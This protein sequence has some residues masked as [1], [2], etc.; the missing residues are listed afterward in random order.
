M[1]YHKHRLDPAFSIKPLRIDGLVADLVSLKADQ[2]LLFFLGAGCSRS[3]GIPTAAEL[4]N[5]R[6][7]P[8]LRERYDPKW[9]AELFP[10]FNRSYGAEHYGAVFETLYPHPDQR[11]REI[12]DLTDGVMPGIGYALL[13]QIMSD[14][15]RRNFNIVLTT[16]FDDLLQDSLFLYA[17]RKPLAVIHESL[18]S[19]VDSKRSRPTVVKIHGDARIAPKNTDLETSR[20]DSAVVT[21]VAELLRSTGIVFLGYGGGD[22]SVADI[23]CRMTSADFSG[24]LYWVNRSLPSNRKFR[25]WL[26]Q[27]PNSFWIQ[28][29]DFDG[30][31]IRL[32]NAALQRSVLDPPLIG[33]IVDDGYQRYCSTL[34]A[35]SGRSSGLRPEKNASNDFSR[36]WLAS[37]PGTRRLWE[38]VTSAPL[39]RARF[40]RYVQGDSNVA[41]DAY[42]KALEEDAS[43]AALC[44]Y[45]GFMTELG[46]EV[47][48]TRLKFPSAPERSTIYSLALSQASETGNTRVCAILLGA[49]ADPNVHDPDGDTALIRAIERAYFEVASTLIAHNADVNLADDRGFTP[50]V[51][52]ASGGDVNLLEALRSA[53][54]QLE[55][56]TQ[57]GGTAL[58]MAAYHGHLS[59]LRYL[60][61]LGLDVNAVNSYRTTALIWAAHRGHTEIVRAL[62]ESG[63]QLDSQN[64]FGK[65]ALM[66]GILNDNVDV[67]RA[68]VASGADPTRPKFNGKSALDQALEEGNTLIIDLL[69][70]G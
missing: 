61:G 28:E 34:M 16:N 35:Y 5:Q 3:S 25:D 50:F 21:R 19:Y 47:Y 32:F 24:G 7:M 33:K 57:D 66:E 51:V 44:E 68:L 63:A 31:M 48:L 8:R 9:L 39:T 60:L 1:P 59:A 53:G 14:P 12:E 29:S 2:Q 27:K 18:V 15:V 36:E 58:M 4:V 69:T 10:N 45:L 13:A 37:S 55:K 54:A 6:W 46:K 70:R 22:Q 20:L 26:V 40:A 49:G 30:L 17:R 42:V 43:G 67:V 62:I 11:Q 65:T 23:F 38:S 56:T 52:A 41:I 64:V